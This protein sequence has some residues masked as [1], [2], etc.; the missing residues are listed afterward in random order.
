VLLSG[1]GHI[2]DVRGNE[3]V[4]GF[5]NPNLARTFKEGFNAE[6]LAEAVAE[7]IGG[8]WRITVGTG[9]GSGPRGGAPGGQRATQPAPTPP[10]A[11]STPG[12]APGDEAMDE[13]PPDDDDPYADRQAPVVSGE[14]AAVALLQ[15]GLGAKV[16]EEIS[17]DS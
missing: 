3:I 8:K 17:P 15:R 6:P 11:S 4:L 13:V 16:I 12:F 2:V 5:D 14:D 9:S 1:D 10:A 7:V